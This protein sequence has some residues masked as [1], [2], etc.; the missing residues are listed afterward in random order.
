M[1]GNIMWINITLIY[2]FYSIHYFL[3]IKN[4][5][6]SSRYMFFSLIKK[7]VFIG[8]LTSEYKLRKEWSTDINKKGV[9]PHESTNASSFLSCYYFF[10]NY[11][12][13]EIIIKSK[14]V[15]NLVSKNINFLT[16]FLLCHDN[17]HVPIAY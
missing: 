8:Y 2:L 16:L 14:N 1:A 4:E 9:K 3:S 15:G 17:I 11:I 7:V 13:T 5:M 6:Y 10:G 12:H